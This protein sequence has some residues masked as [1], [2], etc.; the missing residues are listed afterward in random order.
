MPILPFAVEQ[1]RKHAVDAVETMPV[2]RFEGSGNFREWRNIRLTSRFTPAA[3]ETI[4]R[5]RKP[6]RIW[7][8]CGGP[9]GN[10]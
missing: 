3:R 5:F 8:A 7:A 6:T 10:P 4:G 1:L 9:D 2:E